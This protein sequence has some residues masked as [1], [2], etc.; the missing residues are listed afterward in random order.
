MVDKSSKKLKT[1]LE[2]VSDSYPDFVKGGLSIVKGNP[3]R[4][5]L[6]LK[7][8]ESNP[9]ATTSDIIR[10]ETEKILFIKPIS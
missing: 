3:E 9:E 10:F 4:A 7:F 6:L 8:I 5:S 2:N 1:A